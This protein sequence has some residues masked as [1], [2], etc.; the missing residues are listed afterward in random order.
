MAQLQTLI[1]E[2]KRL[3]NEATDTSVGE[4]GSG[5]GTVTTQS[6]A[7]ITDYINEAVNECCRTC[8]YVPAK[9]TITQ[10]NGIINLAEV[11]LDSNYIPTA[12]GT[13]PITNI[14]DASKMWFPMSVFVGATP[15]VH[16]AEPNL[17]AFNLSFETSTGTATH[18]YRA[19]QYIIKTYPMPTTSTAF[20]VY[21]A[22]TVTNYVNLT[23]NITIIPDDLQLK[24]WAAYAA[25]KL[26]LKNTD[27]PSLAQRAFWGN[28]YNEV[29]MRLWSSLDSMLRMPGAPFAIPPV[30]AAQTG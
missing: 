3:L 23:D 11:S 24:C 16:C 28:W 25:Y 26:T 30:T 13:P 21:G 20:T 14:N 2:T 17:R 4:V 1:A 18:W 22:G 9:A 15:L 5:S 19:G 12:T 8:I 6:D 29:R 10:A 27:D 7:T